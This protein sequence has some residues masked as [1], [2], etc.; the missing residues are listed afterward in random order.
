MSD[1]FS[2]VP[3]VEKKYQDRVVKDPILFTDENPELYF[4]TDVF[5]KGSLLKTIVRMIRTYLKRDLGIQILYAYDV[6]AEE[7]D[8][9]SGL[10]SFL[11]EHA[12]D[13][14]KYIPANSKVV[15]LGRGL[16]PITMDTDVNYTGFLDY[17]WNKT[18]FY[19]PNLKS[20]V[21][22]AAPIFALVEGNKPKNN[23]ELHHFKHQ[24]N[25]AENYE[26]VPKRIPVAKKIVIDNPSKFF[27]EFDHYDLLSWDTETEGFDCMRDKII[28]LTIAFDSKTGYYMDWD[29]VDPEEWNHFLRNKRQIGA[30]LKFD[31]RFMARYG[32]TNAIPYFDTLH[33]G[34]CLNEMRSNSLKTHAWHYTTYGGYDLEL[35]KFKK[36]FRATKNYGQINKEILVSYATMDPIVDFAVYEGQLKH[37]AEDPLLENYFWEHVMPTVRMFTEIEREGVF[38]NWDNIRKY[39]KELRAKQQEFE[40]KIIKQVGVQFD[41]GSS[42]Q[43]GDMLEKRLDLP[44]L[45]RR[46]DDRYL[47]N[48]EVLTEWK[49]QGY[50]IAEDILE[51]RGYSALLNT[52]IG[53]EEDKSAYWEYKAPD[54]KIYPSYAVMMAKS[55]RNKA[56]SP[57]MQQVPHHGDK[58]WMIRSFFST[59]DENYK[60]ADFDYSGLQLRIAAIMSGDENM[61]HAFLELGGDLHSMT[62]HPTFFS[63]ETDFVTVTYED[64]STEDLLLKEYEEITSSK[65]KKKIVSVS[66]PFKKE[67]TLEEFLSKKKKSDYIS[68]LRFTAKGINFG[69]LFGGKA[70]TVTDNGV[71]KE[72]TI[73]MCKD[74]ISEKDLKV[75]TDYRTGKP[76]YFLT[77]GTYFRELFF[78]T[79]PGLVDWHKSYH[80]FAKKNGYMRAVHGARRLLPQLL[81]CGDDKK[82]E[83]NLLNIS[84]NS[85]VQNFE[86]VM[87]SR[88]M[89][90]LHSYMKENNLKSRLWSTVHDAV[91]FYIHKDDEED[92]ASVIPEI[93]GKDYPE[94]N[95]IPIEVE[96]DIGDPRDK[97]NPTWWGYGPA[98]GK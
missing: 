48:E 8:T 81:H 63:G 6:K 46:K 22:P 82:T 32:V 73:K 44:C 74:F 27:K 10:F 1:F 26:A 17:V 69:C 49:K 80:N 43:L 7:K 35:E 71:R 3:N 83:S 16:Y 9:K 70:G 59:P 47:T 64:G 13:L 87:I 75:V 4:V 61:R 53:R 79:Y 96:G 19:A 33:A 31:C 50:K 85:P 24:L 92:L 54:G 62:A 23:Y 88:A 60:I 66:E 56:H 91:G 12:T 11:L 21:F 39:E 18:E 51:Y 72:W 77:V 2:F 90:G 78:K 52:F 42:A 36:K 84:L 45:G 28:C 65:R 97:E 41:V 5:L 86:I 57:N 25:H 30:N 55:H 68:E 20:Y 14:S 95:G 37:L 93:M 40:L 89:R 58:A 15:T 34:H 98:Y 38:I 67:L 76:D 94:Y 29:D